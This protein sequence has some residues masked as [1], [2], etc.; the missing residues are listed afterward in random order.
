MTDSAQYPPI[1]RLI[2]QRAPILMVDRLL[3]A[4]DDT[5]RTCLTVRPDNFFLDEDGRLD[6]TGLI[7]HI[8][9]SASALAGYK[10]LRAGSSRPP[11]GYI[12]EVKRFRLLRRPQMGETV[13]TDISFGAETGGIT[14]LTGETRVGDETVAS[15]QMK[16]SIA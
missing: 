8:A 6:E 12:G 3:E 15:T 4:Q 2:P 9:Q 5:A 13:I 10:A 7:E 16:I 11:V 14:L 1:D